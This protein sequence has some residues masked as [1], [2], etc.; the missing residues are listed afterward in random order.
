MTNRRLVDYD[1]RQFRQ[2]TDE[3]KIAC[4][5]NVTD[6]AKEA[7]AVGGG[8]SRGWRCGVVVGSTYAY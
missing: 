7:K 3:E 8:E 2:A 1:G 6:N 4:Q 5:E